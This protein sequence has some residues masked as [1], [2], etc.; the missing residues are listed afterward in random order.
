MTKEKSKPQIIINSEMQEAID[1]VL[2]TNSNV[3]L[4]GKAGSGKTTLLKH[5]L[6][7]CKKN[8][9]IA[10]PTGVAAINAGGVTLHSL[11]KLPFSPYKP[12]F[13]R[14]KTLHVLGSYKLNDKQIET[15]QNLELLVIDEISMVRADL[16]DAVNDALCFYRNNKEP[17]GGVQ[18]L[19]IGDLHQLPPVVIKEE[20]V[21]IEKFYSA[22]YFFC[23]KALKL[24]GFKT[25]NLNQVFRQTDEQ[26]IQLLNEVR[27]GNISRFTEKKFMELYDD[28]Y[29]GHKQDGCITLCATNKSANNIN[30][31]NLA[32][33]EGDMFYSQAS[34]SGDFPESAAPCEM[35]LYLKI[36][37][38]V[39]FCTNDQA[40]S[41]QR[42][43]YNGMIGTIEEFVNDYISEYISVRTPDGKK[44]AVTR[45]TWKNI[46]Y[47]CNE[48]GKIVANEIG[49]CFQYPLKLAWAITIHKS[50]GL[51]FDKVIIDAGRAFAHGQVYVALSRCRSLDGIHLI[52]KITSKQI[53]CDKKIFE[54]N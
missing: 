3:Y 17:F 19:L 2:N 26:F 48:E 21:L 8:T 6:G 33:L 16:L 12:A 43:F 54:I 42:K 15:I 34:L 47:E 30:A 32:R 40:P 5:I 36:G 11:L 18:L 29:I 25:V 45:Y 27:T 53:I 37:A 7:I 9:I 10:A 22:P 38:Q 50:Q 14:G 1:L 31:D 20:W 28:T 46:K 41:D 52:S 39:M 35:Q 23:S 51:T 49:S 44:I 24:S 13:V 4:T